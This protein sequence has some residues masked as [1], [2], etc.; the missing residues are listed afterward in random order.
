MIGKPRGQ[1][2]ILLGICVQNPTCR[3]VLP[4]RDDMTE[5]SVK[6]IAY[7]TDLRCVPMDPEMFPLCFQRKTTNG[8]GRH[9]HS[10][11]WMLWAHEREMLRSCR[12]SAELFGS[13]TA[14]QEVGV[15]SVQKND[16]GGEIDAEIETTNAEVEL[17]ENVLMVKKMT[18]KQIYS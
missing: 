9:V 7:S 8:V 4:I 11:F 5:R 17:D 16:I 13:T 2:A 12:C 3:W 6:K 18:S 14:E 1:L 15:G 10:G